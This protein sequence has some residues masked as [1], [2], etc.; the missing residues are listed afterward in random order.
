MTRP[1]RA[2]VEQPGRRPRGVPVGEP[3]AVRV[4]LLGGFGVSV[5]SR[6]IAEE[7]WRLKKAASLVKLLALAK[8]HRLHRERV[9]AALWPDLEEKPAANNLHL[10]LHFARRALEAGAAN[11][12]AARYLPLEGGMLALCPDGPLW[13]DVEAFEEAARTARRVR[14]PAAYRAAIELYTGELLPEDPYDEWAEER[15]E[16]LRETYPALLVELAALYEQRAEHGAAIET[17]RRVVTEEP[18]QE[19]AHAGL[20]RLYALSGRHHEAILQYERLRKALREGLGEGP[21]E[22]S[23]RL[24]EEIRAGKLPAAAPSPSS[25]GRPSGEPSGPSPNNLP[26]SLTSF[27]GREGAMLEVKRLL[28]MTRLLT[29]T[30]AGGSGKTRLG[31]EVAR[32][33]V[34]AYPDGVWLVELAP[35]SEPTLVPQA[36]AAALGVREQPG[37]SVTQALAHYLKSRHTLLVLDNCEHLVDATARL[38]QALLKACPK[39]RVLA[40]SREPLGVP[41][42]AVWMVPPLSLPEVQR[43]PSV[44][45]L[46]SNEAVRLFL[47]RARSRL[48]TFELRRENTGAVMR[49]CHKLEGIPLAIELATGRMGALAVEQV[50]ERLEDSLKVLSGGIRTVDPRHHT[51]RAALAWSHE[52]LDEPEK[53]LFGRLSVFAGG[54]TLE[55]AEEVCS[56]GG[57]GRDDVLDLLSRLVDKSLVV[58]GA[59]PGA[60]GPLRYRMLEPIRQYGRERLEESGEADRVRE[61]HARYYLALAEDTD[62]QEAERQLNEGRPVAWHK[63]MESEHANLRAALDWSLGKD[64]EPD[65]R[66]AELGLRLAVTLFWFW[67]AHQ[68]EGRRYLERAAARGSEPATTRWRAR[69]LHGAAWIAFFQGDHGAAKA[70]MEESLALYREVGDEEGIASG[71]VELGMLAVLGQRDDI[72]LPAVLEELGELKPRLKNRS[73]L[74][75]LLMLEGLVALSRGDLGH[76]ATLHEEGLELFRELRDTHGLFSCLIHLAAIAL[77]RGDYEGAPPL[78]REALRLGWETDY[79]PAIQN[80][81]YGLACVAASRERP[82]RA[83]RLWGAVEGMRE[84][85]GVQITPVGL[86][87]TNYEG[88]LAAARSRLGDEEAFAAAWAEGKAMS[89]E[90]AIEYAFSEEED[91]EPHTTRVP[92]PEQQ[93]PAGEPAERLT[94]REREVALLVGREL[95]NRQIASELSISEHTV[96][97]HVARILKKLRLRSRAQIGSRLMMLLPPPYLLSR[98]SGD[99]VLERLADILLIS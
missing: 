4:R 75:Y 28:A 69:A 29:L 77:V 55:A 88:R 61:R 37:R 15:R 82:A 90:Q 62:A 46:M 60:G 66:D 70:L 83:A 41:G 30:G 50:A 47:D 16:A 3:E 99:S 14:E 11:A 6:N 39:L 1:Q 19:E 9:M 54:W 81:L 78:L 45:S 84:A 2:I 58:A 65:G 31:L 22:A 52:L 97:N 85:Y 25:A 76:S 12:T 94:R 72:P 93:P 32:D 49:V 86:S 34:G 13:V 80:A 20:M 89:L 23:R 92:A 91:R 98:Y 87:I 63:R 44:E 53:R 79:K 73:T 95:T 35:L 40:T 56:G 48:P 18:T 7:G 8:G 38:A 43:A 67:Y 74:G 59:T 17:L 21:G 51:M 64:A 33:L 27:V 71:L 26:A 5:G 96:A 68:I 36:V 24:Y 10:A 57:I 42:E